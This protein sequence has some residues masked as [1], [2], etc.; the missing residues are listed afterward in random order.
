MF[1]D[2][3][4]SHLTN[5]KPGELGSEFWLKF[6]SLGVGPAFGLLATVF[7]GVSDFLLSWLQPSLSAMK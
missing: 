1:R 4:L 3:T 2:A 6:V 7:P 5:T